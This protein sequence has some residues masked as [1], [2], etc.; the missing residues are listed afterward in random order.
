MADSCTT[1]VPCTVIRMKVKPNL[2]NMT[3]KV[4]KN[5]IDE[6][7]IESCVQI[8]IDNGIAVDEADS[9][10]QAIGYALIDTELYPE[11]SRFCATAVPCAVIRTKGNS[12][13]TKTLRREGKPP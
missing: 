2:D 9:V 6:L 8:L 7:A 3:I 4:E 13:I 11:E 10:L 1:A 12:A 5:E